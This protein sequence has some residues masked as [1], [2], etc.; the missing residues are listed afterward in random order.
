MSRLGTYLPWL[1]SILQSGNCSISDLT[2]GLHHVVFPYDFTRRKSTVQ[3]E[4]GR[5]SS[6]GRSPPSS[7]KESLLRWSLMVSS[8]P[9]RRPKHTGS[10]EPRG[11][12]SLT[13][14]LMPLCQSQE[15]QFIQDCQ[16]YFLEH[17]PLGPLDNVTHDN[18]GITHGLTTAFHAIT[19]TQKAVDGPSGKL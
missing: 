13:P 2:D 3:A 9:R 19:I 14:R 8:T 16:H 18:L 17:K 4:N 6:T 7:R 15:A 1:R 10:V 5:L 11:P 12:S